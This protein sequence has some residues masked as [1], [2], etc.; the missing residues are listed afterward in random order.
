M[1][2]AHT[3]LMARLRRLLHHWRTSKA[4]GEAAFPQA[5]LDAI[6]AAIAE[7]ERTHRAELRLIVEVALGYDE[8]MNDITPRQRALYLFAE[9]GIWDTEENCGVLIYVNLAEHKV[10]IVADRNVNRL[11]G[12]EHWRAAC[13]T[14]TQGYAKG[15]FHASTLNAIKQVNEMLH[16]HFPATGA[17]DNQLPDHPIIL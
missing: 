13:N 9:H 3:P 7:G 1:D 17:R 14:M 16:Q 5:T 10:E 15:L 11:I 8:V 2:R 12:A 4:N 6:A